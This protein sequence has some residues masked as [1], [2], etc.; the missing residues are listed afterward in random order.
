MALSANRIQIFGR[1]R[2]TVRIVA[3]G[4]GDT[5]AMHLALHERAVLVVLFLNLSI[6]EVNAPIQ[7]TRHI[8]IEKRFTR[9]MFAFN[10]IAPGMTRCTS[11]EFCPRARL[12]F[13][14]CR[15]LGCVLELP[16]AGA[17][18]ELNHQTLSA[19]CPRSGVLL[20]SLSPDHVVRTRSVAGLARYVDLR[21][22]GGITILGQIV[23]LAQIS[24]VTLG[25]HVVPSLVSPRPV[26]RI[27]VRHALVWI[28]V[29]PA[30]AAF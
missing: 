22:G 29:K 20:P 18:L 25:T 13:P 7:E 1:K 4:A 2:E 14:V 15:A 24:R 8:G 17:G 9:L 11:L 6:R 10:R 3:I 5:L 23:I 26:E 27:R 28:Q 16:P 30:L 21:P 12:T 19:V